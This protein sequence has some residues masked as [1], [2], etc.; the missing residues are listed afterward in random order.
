M[1][2]VA[3]VFKFRGRAVAGLLEFVPE[4]LFKSVIEGR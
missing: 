3:E 1:Q 4:V 2:I